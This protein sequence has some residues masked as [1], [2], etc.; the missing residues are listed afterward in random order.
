MTRISTRPCSTFRSRSIFQLFASLRCVK[1]HHPF[2]LM[3]PLLALQQ[4]NQSLPFCRFSS[5]VCALHSNLCLRLFLSPTLANFSSMY[6]CTHNLQLTRSEPS[7]NP[8]PPRL[9]TTTACPP[10]RPSPSTHNVLPPVVH[11]IIATRRP[12]SRRR[13]IV[14]PLRD[15]C[16]SLPPRR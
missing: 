13:D 1:I 15:V 16:T 6:T 4:L 11:Q 8:P 9:S 12:L 5:I 14:R 7:L 3:L 2:Q 10:P